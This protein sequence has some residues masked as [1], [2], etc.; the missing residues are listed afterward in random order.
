MVR[1]LRGA[2]LRRRDCG[3][4]AAD[5]SHRHRVEG[6]CVDLRLPS[7]SGVRGRR[8]R[9]THTVAA[10]PRARQSG[11]R[12]CCRV[13]R[14]QGHPARVTSTRPEPARADARNK[15]GRRRRDCAQHVGCIPGGLLHVVAH[16]HPQG[17]VTSGFGVR[18]ERPRTLTLP[19]TAEEGGPGLDVLD[20]FLAREHPARVVPSSRYAAARTRPST[21]SGRA[22]SRRCG[23]RPG[24]CRPG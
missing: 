1:P 5:L 4:D 3:I 24:T 15:R 17:P 14:R 13:V 2:R 12:R 7:N 22:V 9:C 16:Q 11:R 18:I 8:V 6:A 20:G 10:D 23:G 19:R 21:R